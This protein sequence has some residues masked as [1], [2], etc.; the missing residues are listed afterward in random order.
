MRA[1][2]ELAGGVAAPRKH[3]SVVRSR[4]D[5]KPTERD[6]HHSSI[7]KRMRRWWR[8]YFPQFFLHGGRLMKITR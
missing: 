3:F 6:L 4:Q 5:V 1:V 8:Q 2:T 7:A